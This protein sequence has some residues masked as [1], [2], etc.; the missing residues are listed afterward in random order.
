M[1]SKASSIFFSYCACLEST[2]DVVLCTQPGHGADHAYAILHRPNNTIKTDNY[3]YLC[4]RCVLSLCCDA[5]SLA[6]IAIP[7]S[8]PPF[9]SFCTVHVGIV[10]R[11]RVYFIYTLSFFLYATPPVSRSLLHP[12][13]QVCR[14]LWAQFK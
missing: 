11:V 14:P 8:L 5:L 13:V 10:S 3:E 9:D 6:A 12:F 2:L 7:F 1:A 4:L